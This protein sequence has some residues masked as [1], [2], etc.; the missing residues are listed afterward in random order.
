MKI[1]PVGTE[2]F[3]VDGQT[4]MKR[5]KIAF[6]NYVQVPKVATNLR[7]E[8]SRSLKKII[9]NKCIVILKVYMYILN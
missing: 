2:M 3:R 4:D 9:F 5:T 6:R 7:I 1:R 8:V